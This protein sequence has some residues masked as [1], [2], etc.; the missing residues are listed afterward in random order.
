MRTN[1][2]EQPEKQN[3]EGGVH[4]DAVNEMML[5]DTVDVLKSVC[6]GHSSARS[7]WDEFNLW[8]RRRKNKAKKGGSAGGGV[9]KHDQSHDKH[10]E[11]KKTDTSA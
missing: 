6:G 5:R 8:H 1:S 3:N 10:Q 11:K 9:S 4:L 2:E 7:P